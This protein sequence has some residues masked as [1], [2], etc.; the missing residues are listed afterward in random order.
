MS[1][2]CK[3]FGHSFGKHR[4]SVSNGRGEDS[5]RVAKIVMY[6]DR[7]NTIEIKNVAAVDL[8]YMQ[9]LNAL[10]KADGLVKSFNLVAERQGRQTAWQAVSDAASDVLLD[11]HRYIGGEIFYAKEDFKKPTAK[12]K[13]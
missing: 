3:L 12:T 10:E 9:V 13:Q 11:N 6:C 2:F 1:I 7:C 5:A 4:V 8:E